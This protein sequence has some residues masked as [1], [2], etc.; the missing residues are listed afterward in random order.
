MRELDFSRAIE[1]ALA[2]AMA[3]DERIMILGED[4]HILHLNLYVRFGGQRVRATPISE[5]AVLGAAVTAALAGLRP[6]VD[7]LLVDFS[8]VAMDA[9]LNHAAKVAA[10]SGGRWQAPMV[11][12]MSCGGG[13]GDG[14][15]HEQ[16]L[17]G[18]LAHIPGLVVLVPSN[19]ADAA[20][21]MLAALEYDGPV[22]YLE[23]KLLSVDWLDAM[24][25]GGR[26]TVSYN[27]PAAG[28]RGPVP[29]RVRP[30]PFGKASVLREGRD[31]TIVSIGVGVHRA[32]EACEYLRDDGVQAGVIDLRSVSPIDTDT[33]VTA[34]SET[35][36]LLVVDED[37]QGYGLSGELA[38]LVL[39]SGRSIRFQRVCT[40]HTIPYSRRL[41]DQTLPNVERILEAARA[42]VA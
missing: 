29:R 30:I 33:V 25:I 39:E 36:R 12:K 22:V 24:G 18:W 9:L 32:L 21:L 7:L 4:A 16:S 26:D 20:G 23:H 19:P 28:A 6:V 17:W 37:Y 41:E 11:I 2:Q 40:P 8:A 42:L 3:K 13:Y 31:L 38:A 5:G 15:Q 34:V 10:F 14:G 35:G 1:T 27:V